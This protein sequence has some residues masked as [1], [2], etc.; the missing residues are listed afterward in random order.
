[1]PSPVPGLIRVP[2]CSQRE[3]RATPR[4]DR[5]NFQRGTEPFVIV[6]H[7]LKGE[8]CFEIGGDIHLVPEGRALIALVPEKSRYFF[9]R[10]G[11]EPWIFSWVN[12]FGELAL[13]LWSE[14]R[15]GAGP[16]IPLAPVAA[17]LLRQ[18]AR[19]T[20]R[21]G[22]TDPYDAS[23]EAY[24]FYLETLRC[25]PPA[26]PRSP[27]REAAHHFQTHYP[28]TIRMKEVANRAGMSREHFTRLFRQEMGRPPAAYLR[29]LRLEAAGRLLRTTTIPL[30]EVALRS[31]WPSAAKLDYFFRRHQGASL[32]EY[33]R[34]H[35]AAVT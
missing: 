17:R 16:V 19:G 33:R 26:G 1:M 32:R 34:T 6:Q 14:L 21:R 30:A 10:D 28:K 18:L 20:L 15:A 27:A 35:V 2:F 5:D 29:E 3:R 11:A 25:L 22:W 31:G 24:H 23:A 9:P 4:Y 12:F 13:R 7:T 8:G